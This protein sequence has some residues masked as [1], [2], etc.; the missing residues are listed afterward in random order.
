MLRWRAL[1]DR[2]R[3]REN[4]KAKKIQIKS[5]LQKSVIGINIAILYMVIFLNVA[6]RSKY[7][8]KR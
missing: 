2:E 6:T 7:S 3:E 1:R 4:N 8:V 5:K